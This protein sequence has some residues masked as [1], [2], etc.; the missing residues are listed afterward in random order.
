VG[1]HQLGSSEKAPTALEYLYFLARGSGLA[2]GMIVDCM[3][4]LTRMM[5]ESRIKCIALVSCLL[6]GGANVGAFSHIPSSRQCRS[7]ANWRNHQSDS[8]RG[9]NIWGTQSA[10]FS[11]ATSK[12]TKATLTADTTWRVRIQMKNV[13]TT[14]GN[15][16]DPLFS[17]N[18]QFLE[19]VNYEPPQGTVQTA[20]KEMDKVSVEVEKNSSE[21]ADSNNIVEIEAGILQVT[22]GR[23]Q[24]SED[25]DDRKD[26]LWVWGLFKEPLYPFFL[27]SLQTNEVRLPG[28]DGVDSIAPMT[29]YCQVPHQRN[30]KEGAVLRS[31]PVNL[32]EME[33]IK[34]DP[35]GG[36]TVDIYE[37]VGI[38]QISFQPF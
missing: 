35:F 15:R 28:N 14:G 12:Q 9:C 33:T 8:G 36:A 23:W 24:L 17:L 16:V 4:R 27:L 25:P 13:P 21:A 31:G 30:D 5:L 20:M 11:S 22:E 32:R 2:S 37:E 34:A 26:G 18:L 38:G 29:L 10:L 1:Q 7:T 19:D 3:L 6:A